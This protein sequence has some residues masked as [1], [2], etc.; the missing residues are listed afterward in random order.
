MP[1]TTILFRGESSIVQIDFE[2]FTNI[3]NN[4]NNSTTSWILISTLKRC[5][6]L[7]V[8]NTTTNNNDSINKNDNNNSITSTINLTTG[9]SK[10]NNNNNN[11]NN[12]NNNKNNNFGEAIQ[13]GRKLRNGKYGACFCN[14]NDSSSKNLIDSLASTLST[15]NKKVVATTNDT[16]TT[17]NPTTL[18]ET[19]NDNNTKNDNEKTNVTTKLVS[20][21]PYQEKPF[22]IFATR[23][24]VG[25]GWN[26]RH[27]QFYVL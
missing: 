27:N 25:Y 6:L 5:L 11:I 19:N 2:T 26:G 22:L 16:N 3:Y 1:S 14:K 23:L 13:V 18:N 15:A 8:G 20:S 9:K 21:P 24:G 10:N 12:N 17:Q 7:K 4:T